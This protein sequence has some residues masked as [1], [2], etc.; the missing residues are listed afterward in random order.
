MPVLRAVV[1][2]LDGTLIDS[3]TAI[4]E[5]FFHTFHVLGESAPTRERIMET[6]GHTLEDSFALFTDHDPDDCARIYRERYSK[7]ACAQ[8]QLLPGAREALS[9]L[10]DA[11]LKLGFA[12][13]KK[14]SYAELILDHLG[15]LDVFAS[16]IGPYE[17][18]APKPDPDCLFQSAARLGVGLDELVMVGDMYFDVEAARRAGVPCLCVTT[19]Y[20]TREALEALSPALV[21]DSLAEV[22]EHILTVRL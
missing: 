3:T 20:E 11:G 7:I 21:A 2:D 19:G 16:R 13:S 9:A 10:T 18:K 14:L 17:V 6:I 12:T 15:V 1:F 5:S 4:V 8:T 22:V